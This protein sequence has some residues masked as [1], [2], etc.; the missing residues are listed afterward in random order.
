MNRVLTMRCYAAI[1]K[2]RTYFESC[3]VDVCRNSE[4]NLLRNAT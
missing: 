2:L 1:H 3:D 4:K